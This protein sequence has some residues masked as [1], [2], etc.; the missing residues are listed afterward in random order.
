M[1]PLTEPHWRKKGVFLKFILV[2]TGNPGEGG[3]IYIKESSSL[4]QQT[5]HCDC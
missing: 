5:E 4:R 2:I 3:G 1:V